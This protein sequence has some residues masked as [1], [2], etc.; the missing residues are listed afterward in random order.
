[1]ST[2][3][4]RF[5]SNDREQRFDIFSKPLSNIKTTPQGFL[6]IPAT[7]TR[8]GVL[9]YT[10]A[11][12]STVRELRHPDDVMNPQ[13]LASLSLAPVTDDHTAIVSPDNVDKHAIGIVGESIRND[14][15]LVDGEVIVQRKDGI[16][17]VKEGR[18]VEVSPGYSCRID[19][20]S[21][22]YEGEPYDQIQRDITY[23]HVALGG[24][25]WGRSGPE[26]ALRLDASISVI[27]EE[28][29]TP[30]QGKSE[31]KKITIRIDGVAFVIEVPEALADTFET[32]FAN[33]MQS[34][35]DSKKEI[36]KLE[37]AR[38]AAEKKATDLQTRLDAATAPETLEKLVAER[39]EVI[40]KAKAM[41]S[42]MKFDGKSVEEIRK[43]ALVASGHEVERLDAKGDAYVE[44]M[45][46]AAAVSK[47]EP[48]SAYVPA[49]SP[50]PK[51]LKLD[52]GKERTSE[53]AHKEMQ[54][55]SR[56]AW[57]S[58]K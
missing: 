7:L 4:T 1:M 34:R 28:N 45:F 53:D 36:A 15:R 44:G 51:E 27:E 29:K 49:V 58:D 3:V 47:P 16:D 5:D 18:L 56:N 37:G 23:N 8:T 50:Q 13:S 33:A 57:K 32:T 46:E 19:K 40:E 48:K 30:K 20:T 41:A 22:T 6:R 43:E 54:E 38:D 25:G 2:R 24:A 9:T 17:G 26:V 14:G 31:M 10:R 12:G 11:D 52:G 55:R 39:T 35:E 21:G 42:E